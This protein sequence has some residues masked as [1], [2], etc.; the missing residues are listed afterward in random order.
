MY[1]ILR[2]CIGVLRLQRIQRFEGHKMATLC[3]PDHV[4][5]SVPGL[6]KSLHQLL[7]LLPW[8]LRELRKLTGSQRAVFGK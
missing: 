5:F 2:L 1:L 6:D 3:N 4:P 7:N 8:R